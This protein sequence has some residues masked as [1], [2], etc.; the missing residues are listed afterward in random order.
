MSLAKKI[1]TFNVLRFIQMGTDET[2]ADKKRK[3][4]Y[5]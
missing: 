1:N 3:D 5:R 2:L 4:I